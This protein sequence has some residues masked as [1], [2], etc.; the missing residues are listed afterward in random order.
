MAEARRRSGSFGRLVV[1]GVASA[2]LLALAS[3]K[4]W[5]DHDLR[6]DG[7]TVADAPG[8]TTDVGTLPLA[9]ALGLLLLAAW[10][11][12]LVTRGR[13]RRGIGVVA[14][15]VSLGLVACVVA[16]WTS[17]PDDVRGSVETQTGPGYDLSLRRTG[18]YWVAA[19]TSVLSTAVTAVSVVVMPRWPEMGRRY[20]APATAAASARVPSPE[21]P[22]AD[23]LAMWKAIE[24]GADPTDPGSAGPSRGDAT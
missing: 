11:V 17:L 5:V 4:V 8:A 3:A 23:P 6:V 15:L 21:D 24:A 12:L 10:G 9:G 20:D 13:V 22:D 16:G 14:V 1:A 19:V 7:R 2:A 18:W